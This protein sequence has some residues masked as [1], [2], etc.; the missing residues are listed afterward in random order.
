MAKQQRPT[1]LRDVSR[2]AG[3]GLTTVSLA[4]RNSPRISVATRERVQELARRMGYRPNPLLSA[5]Q[6]QVRRVGEVSFRATLAWINDRA[7]AGYWAGRALFEAA[8]RRADELGY[9][10]DLV[11][12]D[13]SAHR[14]EPEFNVSRFLKILRARGIH[15]AILPELYRTNLAAEDWS[16]ISVVLVGH[17]GMSLRTTK[18]AR[19]RS[20]IYHSVM[21]DVSWNAWRA[22]NRLEELGARKIGIALTNWGN[23]VTDGEAVARILHL[24]QALPAA[25]RVPPHVIR[26]DATKNEWREDFLRWLEKHRPDAILCENREILAWV[27]ESGRRVPEDVRVAH[28]SVSHEGGD[29][30]GIDERLD[31]IGE[32]A[33][34]LC[35]AHLQRNE[36]GI[37]DYPKK[38]L[39]SGVWREGAAVHPK[40]GSMAGNSFSETSQNPHNQW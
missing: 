39:V 24:Q 12:V 20:V 26:D 1:T 3:V 23:E 36:T 8:R 40:G 19:T 31:R 32:A 7:Q 22:F 15:G 28:L 18:Q 4:L 35:T 5:Y 30:S 13:T 27:R 6:A 17:Y 14:D 38:V 29:W 11:H 33:V 37:P 16:G 21:S 10:L 34:D 9:V 2:E 25:R